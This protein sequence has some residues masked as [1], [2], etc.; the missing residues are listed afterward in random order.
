MMLNDAERKWYNSV[1]TSNMT[2]NCTYIVPYKPL[3]TWY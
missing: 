2:C 1:S 3:L